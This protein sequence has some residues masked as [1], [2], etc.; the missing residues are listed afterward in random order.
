MAAVRFLSVMVL[1]LSAAA[2]GDVAVAKP[3]SAT[4][5]ALRALDTNGDGRVTKQEI[6]VFA[7]SQGLAL[8]DVQNEFKDLDTDG[9]GELSAS[10]I[11][12]TLS[13]PENVAAVQAVAA[14]PVAPPAVAMAAPAAAIPQ[15]LA[16]VPQM[17]WQAAMPTAFA[18]TPVAPAPVAQVAAPPVVPRS[19]APAVPQDPT[20]AVEQE[21]Q[22]D[23]VKALA[24]V[25]AH[26]ASDVL[27]TRNV[28]VQ[29]A[30][31]LEAV[32]KS[33]RGQ[34]VE[35]QKNAALAATKAAREATEAVLGKSISQV[36]SLEAA[37]A[38]ATKEAAMHRYRAR[39][40]LQLALKAQADMQSSVR[41]LDGETA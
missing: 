19:A 30:A 28:D 12:S 11:S 15:A 33:L 41:Q 37:A 16:A 17:P 14:A 5:E 36:K 26:S 34:T 35:L 24:Q 31:K 23:A 2:G 27:A 25:F 13:Q 6:E 20:A 7:Q 29:K 21:A 22:Q 4:E 32:A 9:D 40:A 10:E 18:A 39:S 3:A 8:A 1:A 38:T